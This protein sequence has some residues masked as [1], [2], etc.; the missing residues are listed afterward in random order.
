MLQEVKKLV[1][2]NKAISITSKVV[3][4]NGRHCRRK[5]VHSSLCRYLEARPTGT[6]GI[7]EHSVVSSKHPQPLSLPNPFTSQVRTFLVVYLPKLLQERGMFRSRVRTVVQTKIIRI[8]CFYCSFTFFFYC[9]KR[10]FS[11]MS[12]Y[13][14]SLIFHHRTS[15]SFIVKLKCLEP[16]GFTQHLIFM[17]ICI[18]IY[19]MLQLNEFPIHKSY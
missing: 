14:I 9:L 4:R 13:S 3:Y 17:Y 18:A 19:E 12:I 1:R 5:G 16:M 2:T 7:T 11:G 8:N 15:V 10:C 6:N